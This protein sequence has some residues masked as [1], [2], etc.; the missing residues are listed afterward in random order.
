[1]TGVRESVIGVRPEMALQRF[2]TQVP[3]RFKPAEGKATLCGVLIDADD[4]NGR[5][6]HIERLQIEEA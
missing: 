4:A 1:M 3:T 5:A 2:L 6:T